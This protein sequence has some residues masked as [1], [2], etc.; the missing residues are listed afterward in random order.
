M[1]EG[2]KEEGPESWE[3]REQGKSKGRVIGH[4]FQSK[5]PWSIGEHCS[6]RLLGWGG[7]QTATV[8]GGCQQDVVGTEV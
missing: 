8:A 3:K 6:G 7:V 2:G 1:R 4:E 5:M